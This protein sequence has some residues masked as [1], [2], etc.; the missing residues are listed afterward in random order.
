M[1]LTPEEAKRLAKETL[2]RI[3]KQT[4][5]P[6]YVAHEIVGGEP[7]L[8]INI[9][10]ESKR[11][12][13]SITYYPLA[14]AE[15]LAVLASESDYAH[16]HFLPG[17]DVSNSRRAHTESLIRNLLETCIDEFGAVADNCIHLALALTTS[18]TRREILKLMSVSGSKKPDISCSYKFIDEVLEMVNR[19]R[20][21]QLEQAVK[22]AAAYYGPH[23]QHLFPVYLYLKS[24]WDGAKSCYKRNRKSPKWLELVRTEC[25]DSELQLPSDLIIRLDGE[26][27]LSDPYRS[28]ASTLALEHAARL[29]GA[30]ANEYKPRTLH[31]HLKE[32]REEFFRVYGIKEPALS[33]CE[34]LTRTLI[35]VKTPRGR[36][37]TSHG[38]GARKRPGGRPHLTAVK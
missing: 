37:L 27:G 24:I 20:R 26:R 8:I 10:R 4:K 33:D 18:L 31:E 7:R 9:D 1:S 34:R 28:M 17:E 32:S 16:D 23:F 36:H 30:A 22:D 38:K 13:A 35:M 11:P 29:C 14:D 25:N 19:E 6:P 12:V 2:L 5:F 15:L 21:E 3:L